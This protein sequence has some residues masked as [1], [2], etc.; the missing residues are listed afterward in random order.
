LGFAIGQ[1]MVYR[2]SEVMVK[3]LVKFIRVMP[4]KAQWRL[5][6]KPWFVKWVVNNESYFRGEK[7]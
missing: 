5:Y 4:R 7:Q 2:G 6:S 3:L 1:A